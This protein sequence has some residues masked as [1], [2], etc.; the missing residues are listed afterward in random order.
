MV[1]SVRQMLIIADDLSGAADC[2][3]ACAGYGLNSIVL[4]GEIEG[5]IDTEVLSV[6]SHTRG[7]T[8]EAAA[9]EAARLVH[10]YIRGNRQLL[11]KK[12]D[13]TLRGH[14]AVELASVLEARRHLSSDDGRIVAVLAPA[15]PANGRTTVNGRQLLHGQLL[16]ETEIAQSV[17][18]PVRS[19]ISE[20]LRDVGLSSAVINS[21]CLRSGREGLVNTMAKLAMEADVLVCDAETDRDLRAIAGAAIS[22]GPGTVWAGSAGLAYRVPAAAGF[23]PAQLSHVN[24][25][26]TE[27]PTLFVVGSLSSASRKQAMLLASSSDVVAVSISP[28]VLMAGAQSPAWLD[29]QLVIENALAAGTDVLVLIG[30]ECRVDGDMC[31]LLCTAL[32]H[33]VKPFAQRAGALVVTGGESARSVLEGWGVACLR[34]MGELETGLPL[35]VTQGWSRLLPVLTKA[36]GFGTP[37]TLTHCHQFLRDLDRSSA[38]SLCQWKEP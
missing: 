13:S 3:I 17:R 2:G 19:N 16:E 35:S 10:R 25:P 1:G 12:I 6:D 36:G 24:R 29:H 34:L 38:A 9:A 20:M 4:L 7:L 31:Q 27:G 18:I 30:D 22:L 8:P 15:F 32:A 11:F 26:L 21:A 14:V 5:S 37:Q 33:M 28:E 23:V